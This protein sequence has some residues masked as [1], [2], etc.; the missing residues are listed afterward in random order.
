[1]INKEKDDFAISF[2]LKHIRYPTQADIDEA[3]RK[4]EELMEEWRSRPR[5]SVIDEPFAVD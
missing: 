5:D 3:H 2:K 4:H 1:M